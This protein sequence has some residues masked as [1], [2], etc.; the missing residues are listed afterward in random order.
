MKKV[1]ILLIDN[2]DS[3][4]FNL[5]HYFELH[6]C[7]VEVRRSD[8]IK[9][10]DIKS[11]RGVVLSPGSGLP[12]ERPEM[13]NFIK[14]YVG[15]IP[16]L[17]VCLGHQAIAIHYGAEIYNMNKVKHGFQTNVTRQGNSLLFEGVP[18]EFKVGL[19]HSWAV[20]YMDDFKLKT[21]L[22]DQDNTIMAMENKKEKVYTVQFH[23]ESILTENGKKIIYN[24]LQCL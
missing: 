19:Y 22:I 12:S 5:V 1:H 3:F 15:K 4:T 7:T 23:P 2:F 8:D 21:T 16:F 20:K 18:H 24:Y 6:D 17:G 9:N 10:I 14:K 13:M 11:Y